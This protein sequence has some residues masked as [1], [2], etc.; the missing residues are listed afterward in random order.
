MD[1][2]AIAKNLQ[3]FVRKQFGLEVPIVKTETDAKNTIVWTN[4]G[5]GDMYSGATS[6]HEIKLALLRSE[7]PLEVRFS[8]TLHELSGQ[9]DDWTVRLTGAT[10]ADVEG[11]SAVFSPTQNPDYWNNH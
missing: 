5:G 8:Y 3:A 9:V 7:A 4:Y 11:L 2:E 6:S 10:P 1:I